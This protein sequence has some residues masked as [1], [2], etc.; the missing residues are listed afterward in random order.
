VLAEIKADTELASI[1]VAVLTS[2]ADE[3]DVLRARKLQADR[4]ITRPVGFTGFRD[5]IRE[6]EKLHN[7]LVVTLPPVPPAV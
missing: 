3:H 4:Y 5:V 7:I 2:S 6:V 1:T